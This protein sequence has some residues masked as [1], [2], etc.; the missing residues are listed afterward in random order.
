MD[1]CVIC[2]HESKKIRTKD[3]SYNVIEKTKINCKF[4]RHMCNSHVYKYT[5]GVTNGLMLLLI[6]VCQSIEF[7]YVM[8]EK[9]FKKV[10]SHILNALVI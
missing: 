7:I 1:N 2:G 9:K 6:W 10:I 4:F 3:N 8:F 5:E